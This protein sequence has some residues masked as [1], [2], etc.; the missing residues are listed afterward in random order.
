MTNEV[1]VNR[2]FQALDYLKQENKIRGVQTITARYGI[3]RRNLLKV[4]NEPEIRTVKVSWLA[5]LVSDYNV[6]ADW[7][8]TG[9][10]NIL[11]EV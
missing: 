2:F 10:G 11:N 1:I 4:R 9:K 5:Y 3:D 8:L 6:S 7:L